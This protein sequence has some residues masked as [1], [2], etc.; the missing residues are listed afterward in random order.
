MNLLKD[1]II[2]KG[3]CLDNFVGQISIQ[4]NQIISSE[5]NFSREKRMEFAKNNS[6]ENA[7]NNNNYT[8]AV[9]LES[10]HK[11]EYSDQNF[12]APALGA[13]GNHLQKYFVNLMAEA[14][15][16]IKLDSGVYDV[17]L[18]NG[19]QYQCS[20][21]DDPKKYR[22]ENWCRLWFSENM[23]QDFIERLNKYNPQIIINACTVGSHYEDE[24]EKRP[25]LQFIGN[26]LKKDEISALKSA[27][28][29]VPFSDKYS[30]RSYV[31]IAV[32][33]Y[34]LN[35]PETVLMT[36]AHPSSWYYESNR[37]ISIV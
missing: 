3:K 2:P 17:I 31:Q 5:L 8:I 34:I 22:D 14:I 28:K 7:L 10:P 33:E 36:S 4:N 26:F 23:K 25:G 1:E 37:K 29:N 9:I 20:N 30:L 24:K 11:D 15:K 19:V 32:N 16:N 13:T 18:G 12:I 21:G 35:N 6:L 27:L